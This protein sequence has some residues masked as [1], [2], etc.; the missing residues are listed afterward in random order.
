MA[1]KK[2]NP[3]ELGA[4]EGPDRP[5]PARDWTEADIAEKLAGY[6]EIPPEFWDQVRYGEHVRYFTKK[7][8]F[9]PGGFVVKNPHDIRQQGSSVDKRFIR[10]QN[11]FNDKAKGYA[12]WSAAYEDI[13]K[14]YVKP[15]AA[16]SVLMRSQEIVTTKLNANIR[17]LAEKIKELEKRLPPD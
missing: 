3:F 12:I 10:L 7:D 1:E 5:T 6:L 17:K 11:G 13:E 16:T 14:L 9:R 4:R 2:N 8:G 15:N